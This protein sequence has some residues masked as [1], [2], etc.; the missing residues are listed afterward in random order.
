MA[1][2]IWSILLLNHVSKVLNV[3]TPVHSEHQG[4]WCTLPTFRGFQTF[5][6]TDV[7]VRGAEVSKLSG[8]PCGSHVHQG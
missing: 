6:A 3:F 4:T 7:A 1:P 5:C 2:V 8:H